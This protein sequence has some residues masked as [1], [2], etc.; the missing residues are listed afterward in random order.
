[1]NSVKFLYLVN[2]RR[3]QNIL[4]VTGEKVKIIETGNTNLQLQ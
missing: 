1:M 2:L 4:N 3:L